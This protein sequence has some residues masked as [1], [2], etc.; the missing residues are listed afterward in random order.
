MTRTGPVP[1]SERTLGLVAAALA[2]LM[3][4]SIQARAA[5]DTIEPRQVEEVERAL[6]AARERQRELAA[7]ADA[8]IREIEAVRNALSTAA[9]AA[10]D[11][12][13]N[14]SAVESRLAGLE[15]EEAVRAVALNERRAELGILL[16]ALQRVARH[17]PEALLL[18]PDSPLDTI[19]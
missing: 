17:P 8:Q 11:S 10:Q 2:A 19:R 13:A 14:L 5:E 1:R 16:G 4:F 7:Q 6:N 15:A 9:A 12:E 18:L 3:A